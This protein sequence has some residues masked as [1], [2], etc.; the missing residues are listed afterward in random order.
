VSFQELTDLQLAA[1]TM[2]ANRRPEAEIADYLRLERMQV[3]RLL[4]A[5]C[6]RMDVKRRDQAVHLARD[7]G[8][9]NPAGVVA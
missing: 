6:T 8:L 1:L 2:L 3:R 5:V 9:L 7:L 4:H